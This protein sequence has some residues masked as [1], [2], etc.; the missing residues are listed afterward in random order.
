MSSVPASGAD[1]SLERRLQFT[2]LDEQNKAGL[3]GVQTVVEQALPDVLKAFYGHLSQFEETRRFFSGPGHMD[4]AAQRQAAHW[5]SIAS[6]RLDANYAKSAR[7]IGE[8]HARIGLEP[9]WYIGGYGLILESLVGEVLRANWPKGLG[10]S[11]RQRDKTIDGVGAL[12]KAALLDM[13]LVLTVYQEAA[14]RERVAAE[15]ERARLQAEQQQVVEGLQKGLS[16]L[17]GGDLTFRIGETFPAGYEQL[18]SDFNEAIA[19]LEGAITVINGNVGA[20]R[21]GA[22][23]MSLAADDLSRRTEQQAASLEETA[24]ALDEITATVRRAT[25]GALQ[26]NEAAQ[27]AKSDAETSGEIVRNA[28]S[29]MS[30]IE[31]SAKQISQIIGVIDEIAFQTNLLALNAGVEAARAGEAGRGF[32][33][34]ASEVRALAQRLRRGRKGDQDF[35]LS[36]K[37]PGRRGRAAGG[38]DRRG[39]VAHGR[40]RQRDQPAGRGDRRLLER[41]IRGSFAGQRRH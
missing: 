40:S 32:A 26:A 11:A 24:A 36:L 30:E 13:D 1:I 28:V 19:Q 34:V 12:I 41:T 9:Q 3:T 23:E 4:S 29:A 21:S 33:V 38:P 16:G 6:G 5:G 15:A 8:T 25:Q 2:K 27:T 37:R 22:V 18:R 14:D 35:D 39:S 31:G 20:I 17:A 10:V 7:V